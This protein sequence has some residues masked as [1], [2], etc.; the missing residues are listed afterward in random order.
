MK[1]Y[2]SKT[3]YSVYSLADVKVVMQHKKV[4]KCVISKTG[5][6]RITVSYTGDLSSDTTTAT[7]YVVVNRLVSK[8]GAI[9]MEIPVNSVAD[10]FL[11]DSIKYVKAPSTATKFFAL[12]TLTLEDPA[13]KRRLNFE[14]V[15]P[16]KE[17]DEG[18]DQTAGNRQYTLLYAQMTNTKLK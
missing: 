17:P 8:N 10:Q 3:Q 13:G 16:Q 14:G 12:A 11:R 18:Y 5:G 1:N 6:G 7:G 2:V 15:T 9:S 4:G